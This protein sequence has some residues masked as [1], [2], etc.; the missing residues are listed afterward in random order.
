MEKEVNYG[1][2]LWVFFRNSSNSIDSW[3]F[4]CLLYTTYAADDTKI[5]YI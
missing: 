1:I 4:I 2:F 3:S 5:V